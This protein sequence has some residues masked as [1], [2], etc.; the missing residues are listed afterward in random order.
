MT[1][2][3][4]SLNPR[5]LGP[6]LADGQVRDYKAHYIS[7][8][9]PRLP[10]GPLLLSNM[11]FQAKLG[12]T[13]S[14]RMSRRVRESIYIYRVHSKN[15]SKCQF[16]TGATLFPVCRSDRSTMVGHDL[17]GQRQAYAAAF[18]FGGKIGNK[19]LV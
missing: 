18:R 16:K 1:S 11:D 7:I 15:K 6:F 9:G 17:T 2:T 13:L 14:Y 19:Y 10:E 8:Y 3:L 12:T 4:E 5:T